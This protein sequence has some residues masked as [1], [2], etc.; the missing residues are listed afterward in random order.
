MLRGAVR[1]L[2]AI[3]GALVGGTVLVS[4][5]LGALAHA[6]LE[7]AVA[8]GFYVV[9]A[10]VLVGSFVLGVRGPLRPD[11]GDIEDRPSRGAVFP[12]RIRRTTPD[13]RT[14]ARL[15]SLALFALGLVL[16]LVGS[17]VDPSRRVF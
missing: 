2:L 6:N 17:V 5:A 1:R 7:R 9:G 12:R 4:L 15:N 8:D 11:W 16:I 13:E 14:D 10:A 3:L